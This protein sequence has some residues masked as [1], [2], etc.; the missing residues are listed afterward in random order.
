MCWI[1]WAFDLERSGSHDLP[2][3]ALRLLRWNKNRWQEWY[4]ISVLTD[5]GTIT[6]YKFS[7]IDNPEI[8]AELNNYSGKI[9]GIL[10]H[11]RYPT[12]WG[13][14]LSDYIQPFEVKSEETNFAFAFNG[15]IANAPELATNLEEGTSLKF[16]EPVLDTKVLQEMITRELKAWEN[17]PKRI[18]ENINNEIDGSCNIALMWQDGTLALSKDRWWFR[19]L[20]Y[21]HKDGLF[22]FSSEDTPLFKAWVSPGDMRFINTWEYLKYSPQSRELLRWKMDLDYPLDK[23]RCFFETVYFADPKTKLW[24]EV[25]NN[26]RYRLGQALAKHD[27]WNFNK[28][29]TV[30]IDIPAS[31]RDTADGYADTLDLPFMEWALVKNKLFDKRTFIA[32]WPD[33]RQE[34]LEKKYIFNPNMRW[35][36]EWKRVVLVDD[37]IV[38]G[39][40]M[41][42]LV[43]KIQAE[44]NPSEIHIRIPSPP[45]VWPC[46]YAINLKHPKEL[47]VRE[48][49]QDLSNPQESELE[50]LAKHFW[51]ASLRYVTKEELIS[52]LR[53]NVS[54][55]CL[56]CITWKYPT[57]K[58]KEIY[59][60][61][62]LE[63]QDS[64]K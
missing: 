54:D 31:A 57:P 5:D 33:E 18:L 16:P 41:R 8:I 49:F 36:I 55:M 64:K 27:K 15:N 25:S 35:L 47:I 6:T 39:S 3:L 11:A 30:V 40:T 26:H 28:S 13:K 62:V 58:G 12:S 56:W 61:Q 4:G 17:N 42:Y 7:D 29:D 53:V 2:E 32:S 59:A 20:S 38:R 21:S 46:Y 48:F 19:P 44:Y 23:S 22:L 63:I 34:M 43:E 51:G 9:I 24:W 14:W 50:L 37:S 10:W 45:I 1:V 52:S 60:A